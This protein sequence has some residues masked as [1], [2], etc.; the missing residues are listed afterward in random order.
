MRKII[1]ILFKGATFKRAKH[2]NHIRLDR[3]NRINKAIQYLN[4]WDDIPCSWLAK[5]VCEILEVAYN[6][7]NAKIAQYLSMPNVDVNAFAKLLPYKK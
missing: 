3:I 4:E 6:S 1:Y 5:G 7:N 2:I